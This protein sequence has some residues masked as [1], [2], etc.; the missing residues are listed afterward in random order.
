MFQVIRICCYR[1]NILLKR[2]R[3][4]TTVRVRCE[5]EKELEL[6]GSSFASA[7]QRGDVFLLSGDL[8]AGKTTFARGLIRSLCNDYEMRVTSP[9]YLLDNAYEI[10][11]NNNNNNNNNEHC[12]RLLL[13]HMD[14]YRLPSSLD[15]LDFLG[16]PSLYSMSICLI[17]WPQRLSV[18]MYPSDFL[19]VD[20]KLLEQSAEGEMARLVTFSSSSSLGRGEKLLKMFYST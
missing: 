15:D 5:T 10:P 18:A 9:S 13:H 4:I 19:K 2:R 7:T 3:P 6:L 8:G 17:E 11:Y 16:L 12:R 1:N 14:L 20:I